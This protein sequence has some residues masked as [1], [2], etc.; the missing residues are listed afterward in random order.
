M[1]LLK[2]A[3]L[4]VSVLGAVS[5]LVSVSFA[6]TQKALDAAIAKTIE[7]YNG[8]VNIGLSVLDLAS[9]KT[10]Y[11]KNQ[12]RYFVPASV[13]K[14]FTAA[15][16]LIYLGPDYQFETELFTDGH[17]IEEGKLD[18]NVYVKFSGSP[19]FTSD[20]LEKLLAHLSEL[21]VKSI[22]KN[23]YL[24]SPNESAEPYGPG[25]MIEDLD[26]AYGAPT[27]PFVLD[28]NQLTLIVNPGS[29]VGDKTE[30]RF[31]KPYLKEAISINNQTTTE[32][33]GH[34]CR[35]RYHMD[36]NNQLTVE[37]C[38][39]L[40]R[41]SSEKNVAI[42]NPELYVT[43]RIKAIL[44]GLSIE[45]KGDDSLKKEVS[46]KALI[47]L[48][49]HHSPRLS[50]LIQ[51]MLKDSDNL[52]ADTLFLNLGDQYYKKDVNYRQAGLAI[53]RILKKY[54]NIS[55]SKAVI[56]DGSGVSR[57]NLITPE[58]LVN[59]LSFL[60]KQFP[61]SYEFL[62]GLSVAGR[63]GTLYKRHLLTESTQFIRA[64]TGTMQGV[65]SLAGFLPS[66]NGHPLAFAIIINGIPQGGVGLSKYRALEDELAK[67]LLTINVKPPV[68]FKARVVTKQ[69]PFPFES[70]LNADRQQSENKR[71]DRVFESKLRRALK[72]Y[73]LKIVREGEFIEILP[74][75]E[76]INQRAL[77][78]DVNKTLTAFKGYGLYKS[79]AINKES[80]AYSRL[81]LENSE[82]GGEGFRYRLWRSL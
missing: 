58:Q 4:V 34:Y 62:A 13:M 55:L 54:A 5:L 49:S 65:V 64:K 2:Q 66:K 77:L 41:A 14:V 52:F 46:E 67:L 1:S 32:E 25:W 68:L 75:N 35:I 18:G 11:Q 81:I 36:Q 50:H 57:Y 23:I 47:Y 22:T 38:M 82:Q 31:N 73:P 78:K 53:K 17:L 30:L 59:V 29:K 69:K 10:I 19:S 28:K 71:L 20:E 37:G 12:D 80:K 70:G 24:M 61:I 72:A 44:K 15:G 27:M 7:K 74:Q 60:Y 39:I 42:R 3:K 48:A 6:T 40:G 79:S 45:L 21:G 26:Y 9:N 76:E 56:V 8:N 43:E 16:N 33:K 51:P 63:D